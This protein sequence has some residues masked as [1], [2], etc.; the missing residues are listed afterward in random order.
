MSKIHINRE[1]QSLGQ[2]TPEAVTE[3]LRSGRFLPTDL[4]WREGM[5]TWQPLETF[6]DLPAPD[7]IVPP[8]LAPGSPLAELPAAVPIAPAWEREPGAGLF[9]RLYETVREVLGSPQATFAG[10][11]AT[12]GFARPLTF[13]VLLGSACG[14]VS[15]IYQLVFELLTPKAAN[16]PADVTPAL[17]TGIFIGLMICMPLLVAVGSFI[18]GGLFH[19]ALLIV[20]AAPK[21]FEATYRVVCYANGSTSVLLLVPICGGLVQAG[22]NL[23]LLTIGFR[24]VHG[25]TT[26]KAVVAVL[27]PMAVCCGLMFTLGALGVALPAMSGTA[28]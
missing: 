5:E 3:G 4:A 10:L 20:G 8:T 25:I 7:E 14:I 28:R 17:M 2:F 11:P 21:S 24:E 19:L 12:G 26:G 16:A 27:L 22:W 9:T 6:T 13:L 23:Y 1:R 15:V 18:S